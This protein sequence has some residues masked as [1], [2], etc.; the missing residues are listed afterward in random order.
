LEGL[1]DKIQNFS[2][3]SEIWH[4]VDTLSEQLRQGTTTDPYLVLQPVTAASFTE[5]KEERM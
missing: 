3:V 1:E 4:A 2:S 5:F